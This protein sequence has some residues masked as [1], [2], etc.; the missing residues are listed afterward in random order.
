VP[1]SL[2]SYRQSAWRKLYI[3]DVYD[4]KSNK[5]LT[6]DLYSKLL[7][8]YDIE[9]IRP[10]SIITSPNVLGLINNEINKNT[11]LIEE[12]KGIGEG[13]VIKNY[14]YLYKDNQ[15]WAKIV[16]N[17]FKESHVKVFGAN[18]VDQTRLVE[19]EIVD[20]FLTESMIE[21]TYNKICVDNDGWESKM[22]PRLFGECYHDIV[23][24][25]IWNILKKYKNPTINFSMLKS[26]MIAKIKK[27]MERLF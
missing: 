24:E 1:H 10:L 20:K 4:N 6:Y 23:T 17:E 9:F 14:D 5:Y 3:F 15:I 13:I 18:I 7:E 26:V 27:V 11:Y 2:K 12:G 16:S 19:F 8:P 25:E 22:I 21:K